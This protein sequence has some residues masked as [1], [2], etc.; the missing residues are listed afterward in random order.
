[1]PGSGCTVRDSSPAQAAA[2]ITA[3]V[4]D[5]WNPAPPLTPAGSSAPPVESTSSPESAETRISTCCACWLPSQ[6]TSSRLAH[7]RADDRADRVRGVDAADQPRRILAARGDRG[8]RQREARAP[9]NRAGS[10]TQRQR[11]KS[12]WKLNHGSVVIDGLIGQYGSDC[13]SM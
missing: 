10:T 9:Q 8:E 4:P 11:T 6:T 5:N 1:M 2:A 7:E 12:S 3:I 13:V